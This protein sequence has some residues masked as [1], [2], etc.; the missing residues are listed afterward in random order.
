VNEMTNRKFYDSAENR[1]LVVESVASRFTHISV[2]DS[3]IFDRLQIRI[4]ML[5]PKIP[6]NFMVYLT[7]LCRIP[8]LHTA[9]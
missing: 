4:R 9:E 7:V 5:M 6:R 3:V 2:I 8:T 1:N